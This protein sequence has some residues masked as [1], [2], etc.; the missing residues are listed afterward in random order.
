MPS[1]GRD[2]VR[3]PSRELLAGRTGPTG[4][5]GHAIAASPDAKGYFILAGDGSVYAFGAPRYHGSRGRQDGLT[6]PLSQW[7]STLQRA[8]TGS[9]H[10]G[11]RSTASTPPT[12]VPRLTLSVTCFAMASVPDG[13]GYWLA[14]RTATSTPSERLCTAHRL[15]DIAIHRWS[16][17]PRARPETDTGSRPLQVACF[18]SAAVSGPTARSRP[19]CTQSWCRHSVRRRDTFTARDVDARPRL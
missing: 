5:P 6:E 2:L 8:A 17:W 10:P 15:G 16:P 11:E 18:V 14:A 3:G 4:R 1:A 19:G 9:S 12:S 13:H 7:R